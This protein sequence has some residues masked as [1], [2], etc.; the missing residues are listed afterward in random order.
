[1]GRGSMEAPVRSPGGASRLSRV[2]ARGVSPLVRRGEQLALPL[3][4]ARDGTRRGGARRGAGRKRVGARGSTPHRTRPQHRA[5]EP[6]LVTMRA[7]LGPLRS[8]FVFPTLK[9]A[10]G[11]AN[12]RE[13]EAFRI[14][15][16]SVQRD[17]LHLIVE[18]ESRRALSEGMRS[19]SIRVARAVNQLLLR[20]GRF[21]ADR[22]HG[23]ALR[24][25]REVRNAVVYVLASFR[26]HT[27]WRLPPGVDPYSSGE[28]FTGWLEWSSADGKAPYAERPPPGAV[29]AQPPPVLVSAARSWLLTVGLRRTRRVSIA[30]PPA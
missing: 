10:I 22:W 8:R 23:R 12:R 4:H 20:R 21:W 6:V 30:E 27:R 29:G 14:V 7:G 2:T 16:F 15:H 13:P 1:M 24:S 25:P 9:Y 5:R 19:L 26:K 3:P 17:H 28:H 18:A 11:G